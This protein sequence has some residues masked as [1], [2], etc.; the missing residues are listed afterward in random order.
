MSDKYAE[1]KKKIE[2]CYK[3][4][5]EIPEGKKQSLSDFSMIMSYAIDFF[6]CVLAG[7]IMGLILDNCFKTRYIFTI[8]LFLIGVIA[9]IFNVLKKY[10][11]L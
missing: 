11:H 7:G 1:I 9:G 2:K 5:N 4:N 6:S 10:K 8:S 3:D